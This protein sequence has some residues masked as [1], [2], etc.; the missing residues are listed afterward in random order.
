MTEHRALL[1]LLSGLA[2]DY[3]E[4]D[5][6]VVG[7]GETQPCL[8]AEHLL[9]DGQVSLKNCTSAMK[10]HPLMAHEMERLTPSLCQAII[11]PVNA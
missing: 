4:R 3:M 5:I 1:S 7:E 9:P 2:L 6:T 8:P 11:M 10:A